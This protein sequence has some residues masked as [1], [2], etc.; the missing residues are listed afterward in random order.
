MNL[1][2][3]NVHKHGGFGRRHFVN[4]EKKF[5]SPQYMTK[6]RIFYGKYRI[7]GPILLLQH[8]LWTEKYLLL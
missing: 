5:L 6:K 7:F 4:G 8:A 3:K 2:R 1:K